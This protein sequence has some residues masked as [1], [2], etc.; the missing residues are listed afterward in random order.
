MFQISDQEKKAKYLLS[1]ECLLRVAN[2]WQNQRTDKNT[3]LLL[4][5][6]TNF[7]LE[8]ER[9]RNSRCKE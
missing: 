2:A 6:T 8:T 5:N 9:E 1:Q 4:Q 7:K 3:Y